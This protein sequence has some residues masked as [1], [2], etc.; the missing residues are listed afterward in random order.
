MCYGC[1]VG[2]AVGGQISGGVWLGS[3]SKSSSGLATVSAMVLAPGSG[4]DC[5]TYGPVVTVC[6]YGCFLVIEAHGGRVR[7]NSVSYCRVVRLFFYG[8]FLVRC[9]QTPS[10]CRAEP[11]KVPAAVPRPRKRVSS[12]LRS[13]IGPP[14]PPWIPGCPG[15]LPEIGTGARTSQYASNTVRISSVCA[16]RCGG[17][18]E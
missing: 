9:F 4:S 12:G 3:G 7:P 18:C 5:S 8:C 16:S 6:F 1:S 13:Q 10:Y 14:S 15:R 11:S 17:V 2:D